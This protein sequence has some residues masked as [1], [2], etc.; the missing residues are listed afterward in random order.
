MF[1]EYCF[2]LFALH[3]FKFCK[4]AFF[5]FVMVVIQK[6]IVKSTFSNGDLTDKIKTGE[7]LCPVTIIFGVL[8]KF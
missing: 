7:L 3:I 6:K 1:I 2:F 8:K 4:N 5:N